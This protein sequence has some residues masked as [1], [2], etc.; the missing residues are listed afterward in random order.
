VFGVVYVKVG[1]G[2][3][4]STTPSFWKSQ[5]RESTVP[6][7]VSV[8]CTVRGATPL[9]GAAVNDAAG[10]EGPPP[11]SESNEWK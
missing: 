6:L 4:E 11:P 5:A 2:A 1:L 9:V 8:N 3:V 10:G 7:D